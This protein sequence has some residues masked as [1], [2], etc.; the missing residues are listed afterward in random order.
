MRY[1]VSKMIKEELEEDISDVERMCTPGVATENEVE[2]FAALIGGLEK[3]DYKAS[4]F[5]VVMEMAED[6][7]EGKIDELDFYRGVKALINRF[8]ERDVR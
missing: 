3:M 6:V 1:E 8:K 5:D 2:R 4:K 7:V